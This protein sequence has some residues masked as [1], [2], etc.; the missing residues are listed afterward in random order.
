MFR[1]A[2]V[3]PAAGVTIGAV[4]NRKPA[5]LSQNVAWWDVTITVANDAAP[6]SRTLAL[7][8]PNGRSSAATVL[9]PAHVPTISNLRAQPAAGG[10]SVDVQF[11]I[12]DASADVGDLPYVWFTI[13]CGGEPTVGVVRGNH[14]A[15]TVRASIPRPASSACDLEV[16]A[17]D[18][19]KVD[20]NTLNTRIP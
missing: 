9:I 7:L 20:S 8:T 11:A 14:A 19:G 2:E 15:G 13:A 5:E 10:K 3:T 18:A 4:S 6:G 12:A 17:S 16:R 1:G